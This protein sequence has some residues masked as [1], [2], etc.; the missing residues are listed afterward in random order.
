MQISDSGSVVVVT[1]VSGQCQTLWRAIESYHVLGRR[2]FVLD[3]SHVDLLNSVNIAAII[4][5]RS[6]LTA[7]G[8]KLALAGLKPRMQE[9]FRVFRL[10][11]LFD[12]GLDLAAATRAVA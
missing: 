4:T 12:L 6:K 1:V 2:S 9:I 8:G 11:R 5:V 3:L 10:D 7:T